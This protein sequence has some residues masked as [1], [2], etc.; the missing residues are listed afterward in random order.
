MKGLIDTIACS[1]FEKG[2][3]KKRM[4]VHEKILKGYLGIWQSMSL[5]L[6]QINK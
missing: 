3:Q 5:H 6:S 4:L 2:F 1:F